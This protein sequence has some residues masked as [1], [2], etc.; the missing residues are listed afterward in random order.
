MG[1]GDEYVKIGVPLMAESWYEDVR[2][3][4]TFATR[5]VQGADTAKK[6]KPKPKITDSGMKRGALDSFVKMTKPGISHSTVGNAESPKRAHKA[7]GNSEPVCGRSEKLPASSQKHGKPVHNQSG[8]K[9]GNRAQKPRSKAT[10]ASTGRGSV[11]VSKPATP[12][13]SDNPWT[14]SKR[15]ND[16]L[17]VKLPVGSR[18]SALGIYSAQDVEDSN[19]NEQSD[20]ELVESSAPMPESP[21]A[22]RKHAD[23][24]SNSSADEVAK[25]R[26]RR[27]SRRNSVIST[28]RKE[29]IDLN[30]T[31]ADE[32]EPTSLIA[33]KQRRSQPQVPSPRGSCIQIASQFQQRQDTGKQTSAV[34]ARSEN[35]NRKL[36]FGN[37]NAERVSPS[38]DSDDLP[39][40]SVL[41]S[42]GFYQNTKPL[43]T[44]PR[45]SPRSPSPTKRSTKPKGFVMVRESLEGAWRDV[46]PLEAKAKPT[47]VIASVEVV[48]LT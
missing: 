2:H 42:A 37:P 16:T 9:G 38:S 48:D 18:Y 30:T 29:I 39:S 7:A 19:D 43:P 12:S 40:P 26:H 31:T 17:N 23:H 41:L 8:V 27:Q 33:M 24:I 1:F 45:H 36:D 14:N 47:K 21:T 32:S 15:P 20:A 6:S 3:P 13:H 22:K 5:K 35:A 25:T 44:G 4:K 28:V 46:D 11:P 34:S 10:V